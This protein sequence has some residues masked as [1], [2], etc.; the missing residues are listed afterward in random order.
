M[1]MIW[2]T[3]ISVCYGATSV[4]TPNIDRL[5]T[6]G[7]KFTN[8]YATAATCTPSRYSLLTGEYAWRRKGTGIAAGDAAMIID[9]STVTMSDIFKRADY[10]TAV[11][12]KWHLGLGPGKIDWNK[13][14]K[15]G[16]LELGFDY[17]FI[18]PATGDRVP[19]VYVENYKVVGLD[20]EDPLHVNYRKNFKDE[21]T[22]KSH[23]DE[24]LYT[25]DG[26]HSGSI[27]NGVSR[28]GFQKG[29]KSAMWN[30]ETMAA[31]L[32]LKCEEFIESDSKKPFFLFFSLHDI[33]V[34]RIPDKQFQGVTGMGYRGDVIVQLDWTVGRIMEILEEN[35]LVENTMLIVTSDNGPVLND[36]YQDESVKRIGE[37]KPSG[38]LRGGKYS[39][40]EA[41]TRVPFV[42]RW[43]EKIE[44]KKVVDAPFSQVD[45]GATFADIIGEDLKTDQELPDSL[46]QKDVL[47]GTLKNPE[48]FRSYIVQEGIMGHLSIRSDKWKYLVPGE[49]ME[50]SLG[51]RY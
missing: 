5:A 43:P 36:G 48:K 6:E 44:S 9:P 29:G 50:K 42:V 47:L 18:I 15:P 14:I 35:N 41:G 51:E 28:I 22:G 17:S 23:K 33:H 37:H 24:L 8:A 13:E 27:V 20:P 34:P 38:N 16:P 19:T 32:S 1:Q 11:I 12:G 30:D 45:L 10:R 7:I 31:D 40:F 49:G 26:Q 46:N 25:A 3:V 4:S 21:P 39:N 2:V